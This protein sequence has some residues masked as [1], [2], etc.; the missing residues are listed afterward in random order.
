MRALVAQAIQYSAVAAFPIA[1]L[2]VWRPFALLEWQKTAARIAALHR[3]SLRRRHRIALLGR[4]DARLRTEFV[5]RVQAGHRLQCCAALAAGR[6]RVAAARAPRR[7]PSTCRRWLIVAAVCTAA[8]TMAIA[9]SDA[10]S[11]HIS[12]RRSGLSPRT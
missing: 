2:A 3:L 7:A 6:G 1:V 10:S 9:H 5:C 4:C 8:V 11:Q 12:A